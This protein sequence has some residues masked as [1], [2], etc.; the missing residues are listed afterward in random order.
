MIVIWK[1]GKIELLL[2][3][4]VGLV[5]YGIFFF[6]FFF[7]VNK[8]TADIE[9]SFVLDKDMMRIDDTPVHACIREA[10]SNTLIHTQYDESGSIVV[11]KR[12]NYFKFANPENMRI[13][14]EDALKGGQSDPRNPIIHR[15]F[16]NLGYGERAGSRLSM[17]NA[18]WI[19]KGWVKPKIYE[20]FNPSRII[21]EL[22]T[23]GDS[24]YLKNYT[25]VYPKTASETTSITTPKNYTNNS[26]KL[27]KVQIEIIEILKDNPKIILKELNQLIGGITPHGIKWNIKILK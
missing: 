26:K 22:Y 14:V 2:G 25:S 27:N 11:E 20:K 12:D 19:E 16:S 18:I 1:G 15:M 7:I 9:V 4:I 21:L 6:F 13:S 24:K 10:L 17:I 5:I 23:K 8:L 3:M